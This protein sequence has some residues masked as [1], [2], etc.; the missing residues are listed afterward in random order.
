MK[1]NKFLLMGL[2]GMALLFTACKKNDPNPDN[3]SDTTTC[4]HS[5]TIDDQ[6]Y[7]DL[8]KDLN[9][10]KTTTA[11]ATISQVTFLRTR[12]MFLCWKKLRTVCSSTRKIPTD[13]KNQ[14]IHLSFLPNQQQTRWHF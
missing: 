7:I 10:E 9:V 11:N 1:T 6:S 13:W 2:T 12:I 5:V 3:R 8:F 14:E 4:L